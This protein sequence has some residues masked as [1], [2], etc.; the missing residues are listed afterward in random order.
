MAKKEPNVLFS[1]NCLLA[2]RIC[3]QFYENLHYVWCATIF[4]SPDVDDPLVRNPRSSAPYERFSEL[5]KDTGRSGDHHSNIVSDQR[6][7]IK[8]GAE[9]QFT[10]GEIT[11]DERDEILE[12]V[13]AAEISDFEPLMYVIPFQKVKRIAKKVPVSK[14]AHPLSDE[15]L[16]PRLPRDYFEIIRF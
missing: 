12:I 7:G 2:Y 13:D 9:A 1:T 11:E 14:R 4:G 10:A 15:W 3:K 8:R 16:I 6:T 5:K